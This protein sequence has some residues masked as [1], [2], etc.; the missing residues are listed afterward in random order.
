MSINRI[1]PICLISFNAVASD[2]GGIEVGN[3]IKQTFAIEHHIPAENMHG[4]Y[5]QNV[6]QTVALDEWLAAEVGEQLGETIALSRASL[7]QYQ[8][9]VINDEQMAQLAK[10]EQLVV[11]HFE[12][13]PS[14]QYNNPLQQAVSA[15]YKQ[16][17]MKQVGLAYLK[18]SGQIVSLSVY[19]QTPVASSMAQVKAHYMKQ[20]RNAEFIDNGQYFEFA[21]HRYCE[22]TGLNSAHCTFDNQAKQELVLKQQ[23]EL[24]AQLQ[25]VAGYLAIAELE[26]LPATAAGGEQT[27]AVSYVANNYR[28]NCSGQ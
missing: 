1:L 10:S 6:Y 27:A 15:Y 19:R 14:G 23:P 16:T 2:I 8:D 28:S 18:D 9:A 22:V 3:T 13:E 5:E 7:V 20:W 4:C 12:F 24:Y 11:C 17:P 25:Q 26:Q 21:Q